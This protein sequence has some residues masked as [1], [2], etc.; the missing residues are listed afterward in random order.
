VIIIE[1]VRSRVISVSLAT[2]P[3][4]AGTQVAI[5]DKRGQGRVFVIDGLAVPRPVLPVRG[6]YDP[7]FP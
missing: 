2:D 5:R 1:N 7:L 6:N 4:V 3:N